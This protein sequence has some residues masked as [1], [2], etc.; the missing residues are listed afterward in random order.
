MSAWL[1]DAGN[2]QLKL[3][4]HL[5]AELPVAGPLTLP[6]AD[7]PA[8]LGRAGGQARFVVACVGSPARRT[9]LAEVLPEDTLWA[10]TPAQGLGIRCSYADHRKWGVDRWLALAAAHRLEPGPTAVIDIGTAT[11]VD[12]CDASGQHLG[13]WIAPGPK[14][15]IQALISHTALP[16]AA[17]DLPEVL[18]LASD[19]EAAIL[20]G[21]LQS[22]VGGIAQACTVAAAHGIPQAVLTGGGAPL[23]WKYLQDLPLRHQPDLVLDGLGMLAG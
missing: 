2:T 12:L 22:A 14:A 3:R 10:A 20:L 9:E 11:T 6:Y 1:V 15:L 21:A 8:W 19:T 16:Q 17:D 7:L 23:L 5:G 18:D 4:Q 13:G